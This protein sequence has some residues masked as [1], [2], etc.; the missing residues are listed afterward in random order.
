MGNKWA[1][2]TTKT[3]WISIKIQS[4]ALL[5]CYDWNEFSCMTLKFDVIACVA[6]WISG[7]ALAD[8]AGRLQE[9][10]VSHPSL[11][12]NKYTPVLLICYYW[13]ELSCTSDFDILYMSNWVAWWLSGLTLVPKAGRLERYWVQA[14]FSAKVGFKT[15]IQ[16]SIRKVE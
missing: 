1:E 12:A 13:N 7:L 6:C 14:L 9:I 3:R 5:I 2:I 4:Q 16:N 15:P 10:L 11:V 8:K